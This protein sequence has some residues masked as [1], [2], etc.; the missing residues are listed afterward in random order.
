MNNNNKINFYIAMVSVRS[1][2]Q[3]RWLTVNASRLKP[4]HFTMMKS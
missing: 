1:R 4:Q 2:L 3:R